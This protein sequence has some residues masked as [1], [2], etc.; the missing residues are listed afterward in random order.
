YGPYWQ[1]ILENGCEFHSFQI[2]IA[3]DYL[4]RQSESKMNA[5]EKEN[6]VLVCAQ[7]N[8]H[9]DYI[10][11][12]EILLTY[13]H[14]H[15]DW[16]VV[17]K[18]HPQEKN[19]DVYYALSSKG[20][21]IRDVEIPLDVLL[22]NSKIQISIYSTTFYD[23]LGMGV[24]NFS[25][26]NYGSMSDYAKSM[27]TEEVAIP[28]LASEDPIDKFHS[29]H[30]D[31]LKLTPREDVYDKFNPTLIRDVIELSEVHN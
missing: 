26:Q 27:I 1:R 19:K 14:K 23:A 30:A 13:M 3:G 16:H 28:L 8:L 4:Y 20:V 22:Q 17:I 6:I 29:I 9:E 11:Y 25:L 21:E 31:S 18:L 5:I 24:C 10:S 2:H 12:I 15:P 7:K